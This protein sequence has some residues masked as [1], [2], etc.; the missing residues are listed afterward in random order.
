MRKYEELAQ[1]IVDNVGG[2][3]NITN[4]TH[5]V[6]RLRF[7]L[8]DETLANDTQLNQT[9]GVVTVMK[10][11]GQYQVVIGS[12][13][14]AVYAE[15]AP[16]IGLD[17]KII[18][19]TKPEKMSLMDA[20]I[21]LI[22]T[23]FQPFLGIM[24]AGGMVKGVNGLLL[25][26]NLYTNTSGTY[27]M[28]NGI[29]DTIFYFMPIIIGY[30]AAKKFNLN[31]FVGMAIGGALVYPSLQLGVLETNEPIMTLFEGSL[32]A[33]PIYTTVFGIPFIANN[34]TS[35]VIP[36][37]LIVWFA[38]KIQVYAKR[39]I[40]EILQ[41]FFVPFVVILISI[42]IGFLA[43]GP[44]ITVFTNLLSSGFVWL[45]DF[46]PLLMGLIVGFISQILVIFGLHWSL[47]PLSILQISTFG[48]STAVV[49][50]FGTNFAQ[51]GTIAAMYFKLNN[52]KEKALAI[53]ALISAICG[54]S[55]PAIYSLSL[56]KKR[57]FVLSLF[58]GAIGGGMMSMMGARLY[59]I[60]GLGIFGT[61]SYI[62]P[63]NGDAS[64]LWI[65]LLAAGVSA[66]IGFLLTYFFWQDD[67]YEPVLQP[68]TPSPQVA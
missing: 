1:K 17:T 25:F 5:C 57:P 52:P 64:G 47:I 66:L 9:D 4:L 58:A 34:Y 61:M 56:P 10:S 32:F 24:A 44:V 60:G 49:G 18:A 41:N 28:L 15:I 31:Q 42:P 21:D 38:S 40:P 53:P 37:I 35:S 3:D 65:S 39:W 16:L 12:H 51:A 2:K 13:V 50:T 63:E 29:G 36:V 48:Y 23:C 54:I 46:S 45:N 33:S 26:L 43:I 62:N 20:I 22:S 7:K 68:T 55:E 6:T 19:E 27:A 30:T 67:T 11:A 59:N 8:K 14:E